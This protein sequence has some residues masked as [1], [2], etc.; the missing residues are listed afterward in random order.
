M[1]PDQLFD[2]V[3][4]RKW[5]AVAAIVIGIIVRLLK[6][7]TK[8]PI[9]IPPRWRAPL[10]VAL[11]GAAGAL[12][13]LAEQSDVT[14]TSALV[15]G[16][17]AAGIAMITHTLVIDSARGGKEITVPGLTKENTPPG[18]GKPPSLPPT[19]HNEKTMQ[20][21]AA[22]KPVDLNNLRTHW[23]WRVTPMCIIALVMM[24]C[25]FFQ[26]PIGKKIEIAA[27]DVACIIE[28]A[29]VDDAILN[30]ICD[31]RGVWTAE[32]K[33]AAHNI[34]T[35]HRTQLAKEMAGMRAEVCAPD[36]GPN[37]SAPTRVGVDAGLDASKDG[38]K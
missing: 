22:G 16:L 8:I 12:D 35:A 30:R 1:N 38:A 5:V 31:T 20:D 17:V 15:K 32:Q 11:G 33:E 37:A 34:A 27:T 28:H 6:S 13:K 9:D 29:F 25:S 14:W 26:S 2:F 4:Q 3:M 21:A 36:A 19:A 24:A 23:L 10:A 18:P 7:D